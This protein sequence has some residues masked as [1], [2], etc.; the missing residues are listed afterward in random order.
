[1]KIFSPEKEIKALKANQIAFNSSALQAQTNE[2]LTAK[3]P[4]KQDRRSSLLPKELAQEEGKAKA[5]QK[6]RN[7]DLIVFPTKDG[8]VFDTTNDAD[9]DPE[10]EDV[11]EKLLKARDNFRSTR[12]QTRELSRGALIA[13]TKAIEEV[14]DKSSVL[15]AN[16][17]DIPPVI[18]LKIQDKIK[19]VKYDDGS[20]I[21][22]TDIKFI[23]NGYIFGNNNATSNAKASNNTFVIKH[24]PDN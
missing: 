17:N 14:H 2:I 6:R 1:V 22:Q 9:K 4:I 11:Y 16:G 5:N 7:S 3:H 19:N 12:G 13:I 15:M 10:E 20:K 23:Y 24:P 8:Q 21:S 18:M